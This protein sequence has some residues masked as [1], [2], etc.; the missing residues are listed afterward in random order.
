MRIYINITEEPLYINRFIEDIIQSNSDEIVGI[1]I[2]SGS[3]LEGN[4]FKRKIEY[5]ATIALI[6]GPIKL[7]KRI[8]IMGSFFIFDGIKILRPKNP[9][10]ISKA[11]NKYNIPITYI[12]DVN[13]IP[14]LGRLKKLNIDLIINQ[15]NL[16]LKKEFLDVPKIGCINR[17]SALLP[18]YRGQLAPFWA[19]LN[20]ETETGVSIHF[21]EEQID[22]GDIIV[23]KRV[24]IMKFD[25]FDSLLDKIFLVTPHAMREA[26][27]IIRTGNFEEKLIENNDNSS[28]YYSIPRFKDA[29][30]FRTVM[31]KNW[32]SGSANPR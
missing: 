12:D 9:L 8:C 29:V 32:L 3:F 2:V 31:I 27:D 26:L 24:P 10:S 20:K 16:I 15:A 4:S 30:R 11:A 13:S 6:S 21:V 1:N 19:Y 7:L 22:S 5:V 18:K 25:T 14:F 28:S 17:H 23:Q